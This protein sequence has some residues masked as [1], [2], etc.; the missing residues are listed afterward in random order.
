M[1]L[2]VDLGP[3]LLIL[4]YPS[5]CHGMTAKLTTEV[6][7]YQHMGEPPCRLGHL[8]QCCLLIFRGGRTKIIVYPF[9]MG[10]CAPCSSCLV[11]A[12]T[13][14]TTRNSMVIILD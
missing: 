2:A 6:G 5:R 9:I 10:A 7:V 14:H 1:S 3:F 12:L 13:S 11:P 4:W 8:C